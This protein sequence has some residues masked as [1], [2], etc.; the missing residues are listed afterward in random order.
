MKCTAN[1][2]TTISDVYKRQDVA[3]V[4]ANGLPE[5]K[6]QADEIV[7]ANDAD[8]VALAIA[9]MEGWTC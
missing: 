7:G 2:F 8:G 1:R 4:V 3:C 5:V 6:A 9:R